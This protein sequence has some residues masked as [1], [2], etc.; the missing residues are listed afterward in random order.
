MASVAVWDLPRLR[1]RLKQ[2]LREAEGTPISL[3]RKWPHKSDSETHL[4][5][6]VK[7]LL[8]ITSKVSEAEGGSW[9]MESSRPRSRCQLPEQQRWGL[10]GGLKQPHFPAVPLTLT[11]GLPW[12]GTG[13]ALSPLCE[14]RRPL[15]V[16]Q[17]LY[18]AGL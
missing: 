5:M 6:L 2:Q 14:W 18:P 9:E 15:S 7:V 11:R 13:P 4:W 8:L 12:S 1:R 3:L 17:S 10:P 16:L